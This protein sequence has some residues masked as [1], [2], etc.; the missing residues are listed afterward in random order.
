MDKH[1]KFSIDLSTKIQPI[2]QVNDEFTLVKIF[3]QG[4][5][6]NRNQTFMSKESILKNLPTLSYCPVVG[7]LIEKYTED[8]KFSGYYMGGHDAE[9][10]F[11][12]KG[13]TLKDLTV[14]FGVVCADSFESEFVEEY[15]EQVEYITAKAFLWTHRYPELKE[16]IHSDNFWFNQSMELSISQYRNYKEDSNYTELLD[17]NYS[18]LCLLGKA[19]DKSSEEHTEPCFISSHVEPVKFSLNDEFSRAF[20]EMKDKLAFCFETINT[21]KEGG[22]RDLN[23][24]K[25]EEILS[26][27]N[28]KY[29]DLK[30]EITEDMTEEEFRLKVQD[31]ISTQ[32]DVPDPD[33]SK[34]ES[35]STTYR[36]KLDALNN[37]LPSEVIRDEQGDYVSETYYWIK[38]FDDT[39]VYVEKSVWTPNDYECNV[40]RFTYSFDAETNAAT[41]TDEFEQMIQTWLTVEEN[42]KLERSRNAFEALQIEF[43]TYK[44]D[45]STSNGEVEELRTFQNTTL[46]TKRET[47]ETEMFA[48]FDEKLNG[49]AEYETLKADCKDFSLDEISDK[50]FSILGKK[51]AKFS[52]SKPKSNTIKVP[53]ADF[54]NAEET[55][56]YG[57][58][59]EKYLK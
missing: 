8:G 50:C 58:V 20:S 48:Q 43:E 49:D 56:P 10:I 25:I 41:L 7:H 26:E 39:Y 34:K 29:E 30:F 21:N 19:D 35:F 1:K 13:I 40:G 17:W 5:G 14:P 37:A 4:V 42:E 55:K 24:D 36:Q 44:A 47:D 45:Y 2:E 6:T 51:L 16:A 23:K 31:A 38:D 59:F 46:A 33:F 52:A 18:A 22:K 12:E 54:S 28:F 9:L 57:D 32:D 15:G 53:I 27:F 3:V 11:D